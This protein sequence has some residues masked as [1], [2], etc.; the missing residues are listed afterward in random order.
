MDYFKN[1]YVSAAVEAKEKSRMS[2]AEN[3]PSNN[4][5]L[6]NSVKTTNKSWNKQNLE[7]VKIVKKKI[8]NKCV[9]IIKYGGIKNEKTKN[10]S[11]FLKVPKI[12]SSSTSNINSNIKIHPLNSHYF[13]N[14]LSHYMNVPIQKKDNNKAIVFTNN[15]IKN[16]N[17]I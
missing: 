17:Y 15:F 14:L 2:S 11:E 5:E 3:V 7:N 8:S 10:F 1:M 4:L 16:K 6:K 13:E 9:N 12:K